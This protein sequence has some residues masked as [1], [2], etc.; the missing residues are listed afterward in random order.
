MNGSLLGAGY[1]FESSRGHQKT[2]LKTD[3]SSKSETFY[4]FDCGV[5]VFQQITKKHGAA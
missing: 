4:A 2:P 3:V 5:I 1:W